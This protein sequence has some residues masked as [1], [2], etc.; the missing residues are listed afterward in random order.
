MASDEVKFWHEHL[1]RFMSDAATEKSG[2]ATVP[3]WLGKDDPESVA[4]GKGVRI[5][6]WPI[7]AKIP[8]Y[9]IATPAHSWVFGKVAL[10][11]TDRVSYRVGTAEERV[12]GR[13]E[14]VRW[15]LENGTTPFM[16]GVITEANPNASFRVT[17]HH[18]RGFFCES[19]G[20]FAFNLDDVRADIAKLAGKPWKEVATLIYRYDDFRNAAQG[21]PERERAKDGLAK[22]LKKIPEMQAILPTLKVKPGSGEMELLRLALA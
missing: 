19:S 20:G 10:D 9:Y 2:K 3:T 16:V 22:L 14:I 8:L 7:G 15:L 12:D 21:S 17:H 4:K 13:R 6:P 1:G 5:A 18:S 11:S